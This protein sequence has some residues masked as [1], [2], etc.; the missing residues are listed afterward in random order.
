MAVVLPHHAIEQQVSPA[1]HLIRVADMWIRFYNAHETTS[2]E[3][4]AIALVCGDADFKVRRLHVT[5]IAR[6]ITNLAF[7]YRCTRV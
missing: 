3:D 1:T 7:L 2:V 6:D 5:T 4:F